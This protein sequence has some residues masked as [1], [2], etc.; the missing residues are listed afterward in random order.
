MIISPDH[1]LFSHG[2]YLWTVTSVRAAWATCMQ[3]LQRAVKCGQYTELVLLC[4]L[5]GSGKSTWLKS[6][7]KSSVIYFDA[8]LVKPKDRRPL[9]DIAKN[10]NFNVSAVFFDTPFHIC[11]NRNA[12]RTIDRI[13]PI[14]TMYN[15]RSRLK[16]PDHN[17]GFKGITKITNFD[18]E[19]P[20]INWQNPS[21]ISIETYQSMKSHTGIKCKSVRD[22]IESMNFTREVFFSKD[23]DNVTNKARGMF[24]EDEN[25]IAARSYDKFFNIGEMENTSFEDLQTK[26]KYPVEVFVK[27][28]GYLGIVGYDS[29]SDELFFASKSTP[30]SEFAGWLKDIWESTIS[31]ESQELF[32]IFI[33]QSNSSFVFEVNDPIN[34]PHMIQYREP[35]LVLLDV[36]N[37]S[38]TFECISYKDLIRVANYFGFLVKHRVA[39]LKDGKELQEF[40]GSASSKDYMYAGNSIEGFVFEDSAGF[41]IKMKLE[42]YNHWKRCRGF[43]EKI[44]RSRKNNRSPKNISINNED[45]QDFYGWAML[46]DDTVLEQ[47][48]IK[49]R[50]F[51]LSG[52]TKARV[53]NRKRYMALQLDREN[54]S[55]LLSRVNPK[56]SK[57]FGDHVTL[58][59]DPSEN[60]IEKYSSL[61]D[62]KF[63]IIVKR[64]FIDEKGQC[65]KV[66]V[67]SNIAELRPE[68]NHHITISC[69]GKS[70]S[71]SNE[72][73]TTGNFND[74]KE[75]TLLGTLKLL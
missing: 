23:W 20:K 21:G 34:D 64:S 72:L 56:H 59:Y 70:P 19:L 27:E 15:M 29:K 35:H 11:M 14:E 61:I 17:E 5:P 75:F 13:V 67:P 9:I 71:Y 3:N 28:N 69:N 25:K 39:F 58:W 18:C 8:T 63:N 24:V 49:V 41:Q 55:K 46:Q 7:N 12:Q 2:K 33:K 16:E 30:D 44:L 57:V 65:V 51:Y 60:E 68:Q 26:F 38:E 1:L 50:T 31:K 6:N 73:L 4:G 54:K 66:E 47:D 32:K 43:K 45:E 36:I 52:N 10:N 48:I 37:R 22:H 53:S 42:F 74:E 40:T 62:K